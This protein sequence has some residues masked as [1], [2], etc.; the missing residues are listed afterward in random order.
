MSKS[1]PRVQPGIGLRDSFGSMISEITKIRWRQQFLWL[2]LII[3]LFF[4]PSIIQDTYLVFLMN[5]IG[6]YILLVLGMN[7]LIGFTGQF[8]F[9]L[10]GFYAIGAY[11]SALLTMRIGISFWINCT[12]STNFYPDL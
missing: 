2:A 4:L 6:I 5:Y 1:E 3:F 8:N 11:T 7:L 9:G 10:A 12:R